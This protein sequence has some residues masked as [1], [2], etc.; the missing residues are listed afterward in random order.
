MRPRRI[1]AVD[2][3]A[4]HVAA[5]RFGRAADGGLVLESFATAA[6]PASDAGDDE[7]VAAVAASLKALGRQARLGGACVL[8][9]PG[10]LT[11]AKLVRLPKV[12][13]RQRRKI[14]RFE[15]RQS[16]PSSRDD[17]VWTAAPL[18]GNGSGQ[19]VA[20]T[21]IRRPLIVALCSHLREAGFTPTALLP[22]WFVLRH[23]AG[24]PGTPG[25]EP[26]L[27]LCIGARS[28]H[29]ILGEGTRFFMRTFTLGGNA[30]TQR[31][32]A[33]LSLDGA[34]AE[35]LKREALDG[36]ATLAVDSPERTAVAIAV[37]EFVRRVGGEM[38]RSLASLFPEG[39]DRRP[40][41]L[42]LTG[43]GSLI[44]DLPR[45][46]AERLQL[47]VVR[48]E[49][50]LRRRPDGAAAAPPGGADLAALADLD[51]LARAATSREAA[52]VNLLPRSWRW[53]MRIRR[54]WPGATA[55]AL[56]V[57]LALAWAIWQAQANAD[58]TNA[59]AAA[60]D[61]KIETLRG[62]D[63]R[64]RD[65][66]AH[67][68]AT[69]RRIACLQRLVDARSAW[70]ALFADL[71]ER[72][73]QTEDVWLESLRIL[74]PAA[75]AAPAPG[76]ARADMVGPGGKTEQSGT[77]LAAQLELAGYLFDAGNPVGPAGESSRARAR[78]LLAQLRASPFVAGIAA[79]RFD[80]DQ[81]GLLRFEV[82]LVL[83]PETLF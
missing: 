1:L 83:A 59:R 51:G 26:A 32:A 10:H 72:L 44:P 80:G 77:A 70:N 56:L 64:N 71:Q 38:S 39:D 50:Q 43:G 65:N 79:E 4:A 29:L 58:A 7:W 22:S 30:V 21:A 13:V 63:R 61:G 5:G 67:L 66:L 37:D 27:V 28:S 42:C 12:S 68:A 60:L 3:G 75:G 55:A 18:P 82:R 78:N 11:F 19:D 49:A 54:W 40:A 15:A 41:A 25:T 23:E 9:V 17:V 52:A 53:E 47:R 45:A 76:N 34:R 74:P 48:W 2:C 35:S 31:I 24:G 73:A 8:G 81:P 46:L 69:N 20:L 16:L 14:I 36:R 6:L 57:V 33:E 62:V